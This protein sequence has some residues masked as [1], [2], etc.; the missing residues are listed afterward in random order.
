MIDILTLMFRLEALK[1]TAR[2]GWNMEFPP[3]HALKSRHV[4]NAE[5]GADHSWSLA[6]FA[7]A[8][9]EK[10]KLDGFKMVWMALIHDVAECVTLDIV[11]ATL[12]PEERQ[13]VK[14]EKR[15]LEDAAM[16]EI[17]LPHGE[18]G[19]KCYT[20]WLEYEDG[21]SE[22]ARIL[23]QLDKLEACIQ[24]LLYHEQGHEVDPN[25][26][27]NYT[28]TILQHPDLVALLATLKKRA[29]QA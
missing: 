25:E 12:E 14:R 8:V 1:R 13:R 2:T 17:F 23:H 10:L 5:S 6:L 27:F 28:E 9:A 16:R 15:N 19:N 4:P 20:L 24:A 11:I 26:F 21:T 18:W 22:E 29:K 7:L 3:G